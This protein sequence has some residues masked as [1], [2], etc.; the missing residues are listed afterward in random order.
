MPLNVGSVYRGYR[1]VDM[2]REE[3]RMAFTKR[4]GYEPNIIERSGP[5]WLAGPIR[6]EQSDDQALSANTLP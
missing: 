1:A 2:T 6:E 5:D 4:Y 3:V